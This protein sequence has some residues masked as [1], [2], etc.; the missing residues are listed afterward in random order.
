M[1][2]FVAV[3]VLILLKPSLLDV[4]VH[5]TALSDILPVTAADT[6]L[7]CDSAQSIPPALKSQMT[8]KD[9]CI[10]HTLTKIALIPQ[11]MRDL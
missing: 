10:C 11:H 5:I 2:A 7:K 8:G 6:R 4:S 9:V 1:L 3:Q